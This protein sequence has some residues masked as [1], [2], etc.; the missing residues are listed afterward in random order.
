MTFLSVIYTEMP[1]LGRYGKSRRA[2]PNVAE[3][4]LRR[5][6]QSLRQ[7]A[8]SFT[9]RG[10]TIS[11]VGVRKALIAASARAAE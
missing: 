9:R 10:T 5:Q 7:I 2:G 1:Q 3:Q 4:R 6:G 11:H 8:E